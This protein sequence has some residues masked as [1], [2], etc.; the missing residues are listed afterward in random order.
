VHAQ[1]EDRIP[2]N[3]PDLAHLSIGT[4]T[5]TLEASVDTSGQP[6][7][8]RIQVV[9]DFNTGAAAVDGRWGAYWVGFVSDHNYEFPEYPG[10]TFPGLKIEWLL[11]GAAGGDPVD[12]R[13]PLGYLFPAGY[14]PASPLVV[15]TGLGVHDAFGYPFGCSTTL[16]VRR[17][18]FSYSLGWDVNINHLPDGFLAWDEEGPDSWVIRPAGKQLI[19]Y[20]NQFDN[21]NLSLV[22][23]QATLARGAL[24]PF[25]GAALLG[26]QIDTMRGVML[27]RRDT[28]VALT[29]RQATVK[30]GKLT[31]G[32]SSSL[33]GHSL[34]ISQGSL[35]V[36]VAVRLTGQQ[37]GIV[38]G[39]LG[40]QVDGI[41]ALKGMA[42]RVMAGEFPIRPVPPEGQLFVQQENTDVFID[43]EPAA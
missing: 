30:A 23:Q 17:E 38:Q 43:E 24:V 9:V 12:G 16:V 14:V 33:A 28:F 29:G 37:C 1:W 39:V 27:P 8:R 35:H 15:Y 4:K 18:E 10:N 2:G 22:G 26:Q 36:A 32:R 21:M 31:P 41:T 42:L 40:R 34:S 19:V 20:R 13:P 25:V 5:W 7:K 3:I 6:Y 11:D